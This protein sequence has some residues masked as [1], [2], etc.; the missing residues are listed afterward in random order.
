MSLPAPLPDPLLPDPLAPARDV[1]R[2]VF[3]HPD[4]R[5]LQGDVITE[6]LAG[7]DAL[8]ILPTGGGKSMC[9]QV[10]A[11]LR[12][13]VAV[14]VSPL[15][16]L[17]Q[18]QVATLKDAGVRAGRLDSSLPPAER[19]DVLAALSEGM[20]D[21]LYVSPEGL[22]SG[23]GLD[24][25]KHAKIALIAI[26]EA[27]CV[28]QWGHDFRPDYRS[29]GRLAELFPNV[30]RLAVTATADRETQADIRRQLKLEHARTFVASFDRPNLALAAERK[31]NPQ[32]RIVDLARERKGQAGIVYAGTRD[33]TEQIAAA[34]ENA[35]VRA[36]AYHAGLDARL[37]EKR[38][39]TFQ[40]EDDVVMAATIAFGMGVD[41]PDVRFVIHADAP[42]SIEAYWQEVGR[43]GR[44]GAPADGIA[45]YGAGDLRRTLRF[46]EEGTTDPAVKAA[47]AKK[48]R[49]L[50]SFLDGMTCR[51]AGVRRYFGEE[52]VE[53]CGACDVCLDPPASVDA[54]E[55]AAKA[56]SAVLRTDQR[57]GRAR[58]IAHLMGRPA[59]NAADEAYASKTTYGI[60]ADVDENHW[61]A[62]FDQLLFD[63]VLVEGGEDM[64]PVLQVADD[65]A[66][67]AI[68]RKEREI[69]IR[70]VAKK[71]GRRDVDE[72][73]AVRAAK[74]GVTLNSS[75][76]FTQLRAWRREK[77][78]E[79][80]VPPYVIFH[81]AT[82]SA[83]ADAKP[84]TL[85]DLGRISGVGEAK[86]KRYGAEVVALCIL[87]GA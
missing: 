52:N 55:W 49:Q 66:T 29:L 64:R 32:K 42:R 71:S 70:E 65:E 57:F 8:A 27:H 75:P 37:R 30:P 43:A 14:V 2:R 85:P 76:L 46:I 35:G 68:F 63:G 62:V 53:P 44:D 9:Y 17:M 83:I 77:A 31:A 18:D 74:K 10:P 40:N 6:V 87:E 20:L 16:A 28:S 78:A 4:F 36:F 72:R 81:D 7:R 38:Q 25:L 19:L 79:Q 69:R 47:Q 73:R 67:R 56:I 5:G 54:T 59:Q 23:A 15:I 39:H 48:A 26:D 51:R 86:L 33:S 50:F 60:G 21:L 34:L 22:M 61:K 41:K 84:K 58:V 82:L 24:R 45:L 12:E 3:G 80:D 1:L 13:G 11:L